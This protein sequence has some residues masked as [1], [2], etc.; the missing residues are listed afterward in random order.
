MNELL[1]MCT[2]AGRRAAIPA[3]EVQSVIEVEVLH[4]EP[5]LGGPYEGLTET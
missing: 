1:L 3:I 4:P 2:I 5:K